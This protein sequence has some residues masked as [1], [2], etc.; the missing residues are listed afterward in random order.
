MVSV[1]C[2]D[3]SFF[4][5]LCVSVSIF[6]KRFRCLTDSLARASGLHGNQPSIP[7]R[8]ASEGLQKICV[9]VFFRARS[10]TA[11]DRT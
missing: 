7:A 9:P 5:R 3:N 8:S 4:F 2:P 11:T 10:V 1:N 6:R